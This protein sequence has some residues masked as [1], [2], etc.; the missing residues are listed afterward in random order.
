VPE[1]PV[2]SAHGPRPAATPVP[3]AH[4]GCWGRTRPGEDGLPG[5]AR[6]VS[7]LL[8]RPTRS[9]RAGERALYR[10][11]VGRSAVRTCSASVT[12]GKPPPCASCPLGLSS[13]VR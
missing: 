3:Q 2:S 13:M 10:A 5:E 1:P 12:W 11:R 6:L 4:G 7:R 8:Q 9:G